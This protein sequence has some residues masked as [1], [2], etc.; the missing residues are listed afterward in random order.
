MI[1]VSQANQ[2]CGQLIES[3]FRT[4]GMPDCGIT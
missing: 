4:A 3:R 2:V 1:E